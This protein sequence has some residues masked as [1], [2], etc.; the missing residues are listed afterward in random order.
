MSSFTH[1]IIH[2]FTHSFR[3]QHC[4][5]GDGRLSIVVM[6]SS[7]SVE[8]FLET[9]CPVRGEVSQPPASKWAHL[10]SLCQH[11]VKRGDVSLLGGRT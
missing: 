7:Q 3:G 6:L 2:A 4:P 8:L 10:I 11:D 9:G 1:S 5:I